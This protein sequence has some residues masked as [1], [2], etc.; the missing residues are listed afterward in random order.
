MVTEMVMVLVL[1]TVMLFPVMVIEVL[2][3]HGIYRLR[4]VVVVGSDVKG[5]TLLRIMSMKVAASVDVR[6]AVPVVGNSALD[7]GDG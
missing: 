4:T 1:A 3:L 2:S 7:D 5:T 6:L